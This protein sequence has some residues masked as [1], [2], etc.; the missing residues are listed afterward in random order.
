MALIC[1]FG[2]GLSWGVTGLTID[3]SAIY[4]I[5]ETADYYAEGKI[6]PGML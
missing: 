6:R 4:P 2:I 3:T 1:G 5:V